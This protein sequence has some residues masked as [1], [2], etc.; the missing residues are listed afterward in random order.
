MVEESSN[1]VKN[2]ERKRVSKIW[3][4]SYYNWL[5]KSVQKRTLYALQQVNN[6]FWSLNPHICYFYLVYRLIAIPMSSSRDSKCWN[7]L[8][9][10]LWVS[11]FYDF[12]PKCILI[13]WTYTT[14][15]K[16]KEVLTQC[17]TC[18][19]YVWFSKCLITPSICISYT[20]FLR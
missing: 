1:S 20:R 2:W 4:E 5:T 17:N 8:F 7:A 12:A 16:R 19:Q 18:N 11:L 10:A 6:S 15:S 9:H 14:N 3:A 13:L